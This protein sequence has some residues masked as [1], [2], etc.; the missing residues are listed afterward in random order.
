MRSLLI[1]AGII[2]CGLLAAL[3]FRRSVENPTHGGPSLPPVQ[4]S[5][6][7]DTVTPLRETPLS[8][9]QSSPA[10]DPPLGR[11]RFASVPL[12]AVNPYQPALES[13]SSSYQEVAVPLALP[14]DPN[15]LLATPPERGPEFSE[16]L[17]RFGI[18]VSAFKPPLEDVGSAPSPLAASKPSPDSLAEAA[19]QPEQAI[20]RT[21][22]TSALA[23][24]L[25]REPAAKTVTEP[26]GPFQ[27]V[28]ETRAPAPKPAPR[29]RMFIREPQ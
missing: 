3:P 18:P 4:A 29:E 5:G 7:P 13:L 11:G 8:L 28:S 10:D 25:E 26:T 14:P 6:L 17:Q 22:G 9:V 1:P 21:E 16:S 27:T 23:S 12:P 15:N 19:W 24:V 20:P 2:A